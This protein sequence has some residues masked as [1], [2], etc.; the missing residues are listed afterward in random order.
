MNLVQVQ[1]NTVTS[2]VSL[3]TLTGI[4]TNDIYVCIFTNVFC[5]SDDDINIRV[6]TS[7]TPDSDSE[8]DYASKDLKTSGAF[9]NTTGRSNLDDFDFSA[10]VGTSGQNS[11]NGIIYLFNFNDSNEHS[12]ISMENVTTRTDS[13]D[14][15]FGFQGGGVHT[16]QESNDGISFRGASGNN[17]T[18]GTFTLYKVV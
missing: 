10:G 6:T 13:S 3:V 5:A 2:G 14:E 8:Y 16:V 18:G 1:T 17:I 11:N 7:G 15:L 4:N 9:G 12:A